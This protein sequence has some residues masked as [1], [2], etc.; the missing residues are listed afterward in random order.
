[1]KGATDVFRMGIHAVI[2]DWRN[3]PAVQTRPVRLA[4]VWSAGKIPALLD[5][6]SVRL[7]PT[8]QVA[9]RPH[10]ASIIAP[11]PPQGDDL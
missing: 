5:G 3:A 4:R 8:S 11:L 2:D 7:S 10:V 9:W 1:V 6:E